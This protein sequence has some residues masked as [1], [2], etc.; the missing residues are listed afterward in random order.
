MTLTKPTKMIRRADRGVTFYF[1]CDSIGKYTR[2]DTNGLRGEAIRRFFAERGLSAPEFE[3]SCKGKPYFPRETGVCFSVS[4]SRGFFAA[5][6]SESCRDI[7][8]D[9]E[10]FV[11]REKSTDEQ[12]AMLDTRFERI[13]ERFFSEGERK[14]IYSSNEPDHEFIRVWTRK[15]AIVKCSGEGISGLRAACADSASSASGFELYDFSDIAVSAM[16]G[17]LGAASVA[18]NKL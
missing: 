10:C 2:S 4:H 5:A 8:I 15:E 11:S 14:K 16:A 13:A 3:L 9:I 7:G 12:P 17:F 6:F 1:A 18:L